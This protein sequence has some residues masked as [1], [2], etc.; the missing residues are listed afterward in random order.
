MSHE[1]KRAR[2]GLRLAR[3][4]V[5]AATVVPLLR[6]VVVV[7]AVPVGQPWRSACPACDTAVGPSGSLGALTPRARCGVCGLRLGPPPWAVELAVLASVAMLVRS[8]LPAVPLLAYG[9]WAALGVVQAFVDAAVQRLPTRV[10]YL[11]SAGLMIVLAVDAL[12][13]HG[14][15]AWLRA[16]AG[17]LVSGVVLAVAV[18]AAPGLVHR[19]DVRYGLAIGAAAAWVGWLALYTAAFLASLA[20]ALVGV[21]LILTGRATRKSQLPQG[22]FM[23]AATLLAVV[24]LFCRVS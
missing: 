3:V 9:W 6:W 4:L 17:A 13:G 20:V 18:L 19:G 12:A 1:V 7:H 5:C 24:L 14:W 21:G 23:Y 22:P 15:S 2:T 11:A 10:S 8:G 16:A